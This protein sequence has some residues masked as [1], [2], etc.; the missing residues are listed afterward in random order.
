MGRLSSVQQARS[1]THVVQLIEDVDER[2]L[3]VSIWS[4]LEMAFWNA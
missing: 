4:P 1:R 3:V 2:D